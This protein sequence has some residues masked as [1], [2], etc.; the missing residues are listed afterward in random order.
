M[1]VEGG[2]AYVADA[3]RGLLMVDV[4]D[5]ADMRVIRE[6]DTLCEA[7]GVDVA[8]THA[9]VADWRCG[10]AIVRLFTPTDHVFLPQAS[11]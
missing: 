11:R 4:S 8:G 10:L 3:I 9:Y 2:V 6:V 5:P 1:H 7:R